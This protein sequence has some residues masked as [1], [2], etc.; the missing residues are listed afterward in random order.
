MHIFQHHLLGRVSLLNYPMWITRNLTLTELGELCLSFFS[1][2]TRYYILIGASSFSIYLCWTCLSYRCVNIFYQS[3]R[4][5]VGTAPQSTIIWTMCKANA[6][7]TII[8]KWLTLNLII[9][10]TSTSTWLAVLFTRDKYSPLP[11]YVHS[12]SLAHII[13]QLRWTEIFGYRSRLL[14]SRCHMYKKI[15]ARVHRARQGR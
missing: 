8:C 14:K 2:S 11:V 3:W 15:V 9:F 1:L 6:C 5:S 7:D 13:I 4:L 10:K 12:H